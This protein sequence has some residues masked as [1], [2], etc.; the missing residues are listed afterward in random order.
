MNFYQSF[1][2]NLLKNTEEAL[3]ESAA[4]INADKESHI[5]LARAAMSLATLTANA[6]LART[7]LV[8]MA[9]TRVA[10]VGE[11]L[12]QIDA[13][14]LDLLQETSG[15][16]DSSAD[17]ALDALRATLQPGPRGTG[18][19]HYHP[20]CPRIVAAVP[21]KLAHR[22]GPKGHFNGCL[23]IHREDFLFSARSAGWPSRT[24]IHRPDQ[25]VFFRSG[26]EV[27]L[28]EPFS[29]FGVE[30]LRLF[31]HGDDLMASFTGCERHPNGFRAQMCLAKLND[32]LSVSWAAQIPS[33]EDS[34]V[35]KNW[36]FFSYG[37]KLFCLYTTQPH[38]VYEVDLKDGKPKLITRHHSENW[39]NC[40][41]MEH[42]RGGAPPVKV[43]E[44]FFHFYHTQHKVEGR[45]I[46]S[47]GLYTFE[48]CRPFNIKRLVRGPLVN[49]VP[50]R[51][52]LDVI[53][54]A[55]AVAQD[56]E[57]LVSCGLDDRETIVLGLG[58]EDVE[59]LLEPA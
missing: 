14:D 44:E 5:D 50:S 35:E 24:Y 51:R 54:P 43:G 37:G 39:S 47:V 30:D 26:V 58:M 20:H 15:D 29:I 12:M 8:Q 38:H 13:A 1:L 46:Y 7:V 55:G 48:A 36:Q 31:T 53:F 17:P 59:K 19:G 11:T 49:L 57:W 33:P 56:G 22:L 21:I 23:A 9:A 16:G 45:V 4:E 42:A 18:V 52:S 32:D 3:M 28:K 34:L 10:R 40:E 41:L 2:Q 6:E 27:P 25:D